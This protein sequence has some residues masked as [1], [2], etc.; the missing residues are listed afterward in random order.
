MINKD[1]CTPYGAIC[2]PSVRFFGRDLGLYTELD[3]LP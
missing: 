1:S 2:E 3:L